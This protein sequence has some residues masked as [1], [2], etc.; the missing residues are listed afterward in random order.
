MG[1]SGLQFC[2]LLYMLNT[3][4]CILL[5]RKY[6]NTIT[7]INTFLQW[8]KELCRKLNQSK[9]TDEDKLFGI[10]LIMMVIA[11]W[12]A[13][14]AIFSC[15]LY[16]NFDSM[17]YVLED[18]ILTNAINRSNAEII[19]S[20]CIRAFVML[21]SFEVVR[22]LT[23]I[24]LFFLIVCE[25]MATC[26][27]ILLKYNHVKR[28]KRVLKNYKEFILVFSIYKPMLQEFFSVVI[29]SVFWIVIAESW[30][31]IKADNTVPVFL[32]VQVITVGIV[33]FCV[34]FI[35]LRIVSNL[36][37]KCTDV[38][39]NCRKESRA[40]YIRASARAFRSKQE[41]ME[42]LNLKL[43]AIALHPITI[44]YG[45]FLKI[46]RDLLMAIMYN[47]VNRLV[48]ALCIFG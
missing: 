26:A 13:S 21:G 48:D 28:C 4:Y 7:G 47:E 14:F 12:C 17:Y 40:E 25:K 39:L 29:S 44:G 27:K 31:I 34:Y 43:E 45:P 23:F 16:F 36:G 2:A 18:F 15:A 6:S 22:C 9:E 33:S 37:E 1:I 38:V 24:T 32:Y 11:P 35:A 8:Q 42:K 30:V 20:F 10:L 46:D 19:G 5:L 41:A 3:M